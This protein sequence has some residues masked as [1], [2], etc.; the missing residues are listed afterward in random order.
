MSRVRDFFLEEAEDCLEALRDERL[1]EERSAGPLHT[2][3][4]RLRGNAQV[5]RYGPVA[6]LA[7]P[8]ELR[9]KRLER[10]D[11]SWGPASTRGVREGV[12]A[13]ADAVQAVREGRIERE[14]M[15][16]IPM[17]QPEAG[18]EP[19]VPIDELEYTGEAALRRAADLRGPLEDAIVDDQGVGAIL[20]ELFDL[21]GLGME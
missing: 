7:Q 18:Q 14:S 21:I 4:R 2:A 3:A 6:A 5:A 10:G 16:G 19:E 12:A 15:K 8:L 20:D 11:E 13:V 1:I 9:L 17:E